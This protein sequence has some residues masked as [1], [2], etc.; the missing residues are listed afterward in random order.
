MQRDFSSYL[1]ARPS[2]LEGIARLLD[3]GGTLN[4][5]NAVRTGAEADA[6]AQYADW[7]AVG[8]DLYRSIDNM[9]ATL[10]A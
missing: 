2:F 1:F 4:E 9:G 3:F 5:Y 7:Q 10:G 8:D 6:V